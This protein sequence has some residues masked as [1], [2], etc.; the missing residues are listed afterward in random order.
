MA[1]P[2]L[3]ASL[4]GNREEDEMTGP[5]LV[6]YASRYGTTREVAEA[7]AATLR[8]HE[9]KVEV[10][11]A[12]EVEDL[13]QYGAIVLGGGIYIGRWHRDARGFVR[14]FQ[15]ELQ[16]LPVAV[17]ALGP[18]TE[19]PEDITGST[20]QL[21]RNLAHLPV[22]PFAVR[23]FGG[24]FDPTNVGFP[25]NRMPAADVR[26][27]RAIREWAAGLAERFASVPALA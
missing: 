17:F 19:K 16:G 11:P 2:R 22:E 25:F 13:G 24:A 1:P 21:E 27:W 3:A 18:V 9:L 6:A 23:V 8:E 20:R 12:G 5:I 10:R 14:H 4:P 7:I 15:R 26:D